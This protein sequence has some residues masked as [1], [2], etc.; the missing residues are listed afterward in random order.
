MAHEALLKWCYQFFVDFGAV[1]LGNG[2]TPVV[3]WALEV[4]NLNWNE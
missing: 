2:V 4:S 3:Q 1:A